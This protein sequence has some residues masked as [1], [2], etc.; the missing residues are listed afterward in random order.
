[1]GYLSNQVRRA[2]D[3]LV[4]HG[5]DEDPVD[6]WIEQDRSAQL[7]GSRSEIHQNCVGADGVSQLRQRFGEEVRRALGREKVARLDSERPEP[8]GIPRCGQHNNPIQFLVG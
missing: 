4:A 1:M 5:S 3:R 6:V 8:H 2:P 7:A